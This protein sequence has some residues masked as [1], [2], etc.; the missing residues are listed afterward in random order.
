MIVTRTIAAINAQRSL[1]PTD[2]LLATMLKGLAASLVTGHEA[3][4]LG[5]SDVRWAQT[6]T[7]GSDDARWAHVRGLETVIPDT[8]HEIFSVRTAKEALS[9][10]EEYRFTGSTLTIKN[11]ILKLARSLSHSLNLKHYI[12]GISNRTPFWWRIPTGELPG[13]GI[14]PAQRQGTSKGF[15]L[16]VPS[17]SFQPALLAV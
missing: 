3:T 4:T 2:E 1:M 14:L 5:S 7:L 8:K 10:H 11:N 9:R 13:M 16:V 17:C 15:S 6:A 12:A